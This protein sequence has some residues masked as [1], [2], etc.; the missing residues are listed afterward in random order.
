MIKFS[1]TTVTVGSAIPNGNTL[2]PTNWQQVLSWEADVPIPVDLQLDVRLPTS[3]GGGFPDVNAINFCAGGYYDDGLGTTYTWDDAASGCVVLR[4]EM[5][6]G[7]DARTLY[8]DCR[9]GRYALGS[10]K[11]VR[12]SVARWLAAGGGATAVVSGAVAPADGSGDYLTYS[13]A[14]DAVAAAASAVLAVPP[15]A[16]WFDFYPTEG[17]SWEATSTDATANWVA[18]RVESAAAPVYNPPTSPLPLLGSNGVT[19]VNNSAGA[20]GAYVCFWVR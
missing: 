8:A 1:G 19:L 16:L 15:G 20:A 13:A 7:P 5:G 6:A 2:S 11:W 17:A 12:V 14:I 10:Q 9:G 18:R 3:A 4:I